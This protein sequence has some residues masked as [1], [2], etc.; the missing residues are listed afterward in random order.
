M[1][2][3]KLR[4]VLI[5]I[6]AIHLFLFVNPSG[7]YVKIFAHYLDSYFLFCAYLFYLFY[8]C[9]Y[10]I[11]DL[12]FI[13]HNLNNLVGFVPCIKLLS[14]TLLY[15]VP[16]WRCRS[17]VWCRAAGATT[18]TSRGYARFPWCGSRWTRTWWRL[19]SRPSTDPASPP[20]NILTSVSSTSGRTSRYGKS[21]IVSPT[22][23]TGTWRVATPSYD[24]APYRRSS[25]WTLASGVCEPPGSARV[26][27]HPSRT[28]KAPAR[29]SQVTR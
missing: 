3:S 22:A 2:G 25:M 28:L 13:F 8:V 1:A 7:E 26:A 20:H 12:W 18:V 21:T 29:S 6:Q 9:F 17:S 4:I 14:R 11:T 15:S 10:L 19:G 24:R 5:F 27:Q 16:E 23:R